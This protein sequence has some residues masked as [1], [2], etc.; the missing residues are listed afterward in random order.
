MSQHFNGRTNWM[1]SPLHPKWH[2]CN[3][4]QMKKK[5]VEKACWSQLPPLWL[6][7]RHFSSLIL[8]TLFNTCQSRCH[9]W[10]DLHLFSQIKFKYVFLQWITKTIYL[11][12]CNQKKSSAHSVWLSHTCML[13]LEAMRSSHSVLMPLRDWLCLNKWSRIDW[14]IHWS[15]KNVRLCL[16]L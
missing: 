9:R 1:L 10:I 12:F 13:Q 4:M 3:C 2:W 5:V 7:E 16:R 14:S 6:A 8:T 15:D 11:L